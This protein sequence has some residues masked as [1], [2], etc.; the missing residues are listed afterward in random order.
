[1]SITI[2]AIILNSEICSVNRA[3]KPTTK[4]A[5]KVDKP[6]IIMPKIA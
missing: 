4:R 3:K 2:F 5:I 1:M 6:K